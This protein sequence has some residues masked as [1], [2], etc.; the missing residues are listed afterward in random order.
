MK[1]R[2]WQI[3]ILGSIIILTAF[4][5]Y[6][7]VNKAKVVDADKV[8][9]AFP[10]FAMQDLRTN[11]QVDEKSLIGKIT[12]VHVWASWCGPCIEEH[13][14]WMKMNHSHPTALMGVAYRDDKNKVKAFL[15][16]NGDPYTTLFDDENGSLG[17]NLGIR[18][19]PET[20]IVDT[21]GII[22]FHTVGFIDQ[23]EY[24]HEFLP[25]LE[26]LQEE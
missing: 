16:K 13:N 21:K 18:G 8:G 20:F 19:T 10:A 15:A 3:V 9:Q 12:I 25:M 6:A 7:M 2:I 23:A 22:R 26:K 14:L 4:L 24:E 11:Q 5:W 1:K 17:I